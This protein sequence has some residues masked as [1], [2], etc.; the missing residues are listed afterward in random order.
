MKYANA[1]VSFF[2]RLGLPIGR[3]ALLTVEGRRSGLPRTTP[4]AVNRRGRDWLLVSVYGEGDWVK[5]LRAAPSAIITRRR[6]EIPVTIHELTDLEAAAVLKE[7]VSSIGLM[8]RPVIGRYFE[9][10]HDAPIE[11]WRDEVARHPVFLLTP[12]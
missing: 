7:L 8:L 6:R 5:N 3:Q 4:V 1:I 2:L 11:E 9:T 12:A 10:R